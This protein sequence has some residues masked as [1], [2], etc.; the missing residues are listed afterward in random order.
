MQPDCLL[1]ISPD[2]NAPSI[3]GIDTTEPAFNAPAKWIP[4]VS[5]AQ[6]LAAGYAVVDQTSALATHLSETIRLNAHELLTRQETKR[7]LDSLNDSHPKLVEEL[8]PK[9]LSLGEVQ[10]ILQQLLREQVSIRDLS[11]ILEALVEAAAVSKNT[12][13]LVEAVRQT[14]GRSLVRPL[15]NDEGKLRV[16]A[17]DT[18]LEDEINRTI[19]GQPST[20]SGLQPSLLKRLSEGLRTLAGPDLAAAAP[21]LLCSSPARFHVRKLLESLIPRIVVLSPAEIPPRVQVQAI[22][23]VR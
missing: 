19:N 13:A 16:L 14:L 9:Q 22:G 23:V 17:I 8:V 11:A 20:Q 2:P 21:V 5:Q 3:A 4:A 7:L 6:A 12:V 15:L 1:A 10:K 18:S